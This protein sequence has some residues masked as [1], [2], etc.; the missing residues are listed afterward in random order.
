MRFTVLC[1]AIL[2]IALPLNVIA[3]YELTT[4]FTKSDPQ[5]DEYKKRFDYE[6]KKYTGN[7]SDSSKVIINLVTNPNDFCRD[8]TSPKVGLC[9]RFGKTREILIKR[10]YFNFLSVEQREE[11][12]FHELAHC[13]LDWGHR[14]SEYKGISISIMGSSMYYDSGFYKRHRKALLKELFTGEIDEVIKGINSD[15]SH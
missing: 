2:S 14:F 12:M 3:N 7:K 11:L 5:F 15:E 6:Y 13:T 9:K 10:K 8:C 4:V 1:F